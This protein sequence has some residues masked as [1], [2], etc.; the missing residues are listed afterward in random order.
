MVSSSTALSPT[1]AIPLDGKG[2]HWSQNSNLCAKQ[3]CPSPSWRGLE[4]LPYLSISYDW[5]LR[6]ASTSV[7]VAQH[8]ILSYPPENA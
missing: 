5:H 4:A 1:L 2:T 8:G 7:K 3:Y 6:C